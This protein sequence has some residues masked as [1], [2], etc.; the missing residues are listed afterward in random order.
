MNNSITNS[1]REF[2]LTSDELTP[3]KSTLSCL[4]AVVSEEDWGLMVEFKIPVKDSLLP[5]VCFSVSGGN[6]QASLMKTGGDTEADYE[7]QNDGSWKLIQEQ[8]PTN[9]GIQ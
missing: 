6:V 4:S 2:L 5:A 8:E 1:K 3:G 7:L 9:K